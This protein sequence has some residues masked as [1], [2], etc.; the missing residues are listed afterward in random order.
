MADPNPPRLTG[1][2]NEL[3]KE[4]NRAAAERTLAAWMQN[5]LTLIGFG[6]A[7]DQLGQALT[8]HTQSPERWLG[9]PLATVIALSFIGFGMGLLGIALVQYRLEIKSIE[10]ESYVLLSISELNNWVVGAILTFGVL[11]GLI[12]MLS[13]PQS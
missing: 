11:S 7:V 2:T 13:M 8:V 12:L 1:P 10:H 9:D 5:C 3:A 4:R 6:I